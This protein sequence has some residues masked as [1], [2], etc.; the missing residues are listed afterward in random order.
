MQKHRKYLV[1][2][3]W[4]STIA[5][6][7]AG[8]VGW[9]AYNYNADRASSVA[10][11]GN[12]KVTIGEFNNAYSNLY[13][14]Y[15]R[16]LNGELTQ[17]KA[18]QLHL[19]RIALNQLIQEALLLNYASE[20]GI[21]SLKED[22]EE[23][24]VNTKAFQKNG[25]FDKQTYY[26]TLKG[27]RIN[28]KDYEEGLKKQIVLDKLNTVLNLKATKG[29]SEAF[30]SALMM[31]DRVALQ[32]VEVNENDIKID[33]N[34]LKK[35]WEGQKDKY[36][37][38][39]AYDLT[40]LKV[41]FAKM[42]PKDEDIKEFYQNNKH[43]YKDEEGKIKSLEDAK[44]DVKKDVQI[45]MAKKEALKK[46]LEVKKNK[47]KP[48]E[49]MTLIDEEIKYD[50]KRLLDTKN[51]GAFKPVRV[52]DAYIVGILNEVLLPKPKSFKEAY[53]EVK[54]DF[55]AKKSSELLVAKAKET[56][57]DFKGNDV[58]FINR[59]SRKIE[60]LNPFESVKFINHLFQSQK[61]SDFV[62]IS[63][64]KAVVYKVLEQKLLLDSKKLAEYKSNIDK[65]VSQ[66]KGGEINKNLISKL[67]KRYTIEQYYKGE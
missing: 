41:A 66:L 6:V 32:S 65:Q 42:N 63:E 16:M 40:I 58:G 22:I 29:E 24:L 34:E 55:L 8:F 31:E 38:K 36:L 11:V 23:A 61:S 45:K 4:I 17:E 30:A 15:N 49:S 57:K 7:G 3:I 52:E 46:Y 62:Q 13:S 35:F 51:G 12:Q 47:I 5:F 9:G 48:S 43:K 18:K 60:G 56:L 28:P 33:E 50:K 1:I 37:T 64:N 44:E 27:A 14:Y 25:V 59:D 19:Q 67:Q 2:T 20:L 54:E 10:K 21:V 39:K 53:S 26:D